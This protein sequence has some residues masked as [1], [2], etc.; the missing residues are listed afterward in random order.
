MVDAQR[1][2]G[3]TLPVFGMI[4]CAVPFWVVQNKAVLPLR[5]L[6][7]RLQKERSGRRCFHDRSL[8]ALQL[9]QLEGLPGNGTA[10]TMP[11]SA[12]GDR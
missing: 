5:L 2:T 8:C 10:Q 9:R 1:V 12:V 7:Q 11:L 4:I 6:A 3:T